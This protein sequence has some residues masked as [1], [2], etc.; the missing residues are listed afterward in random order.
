MA[1]AGKASIVFHATNGSGENVM[2][3]YSVFGERER[4][5]WAEEAITE[6]YISGFG[7][8]T[9]QAAE[10]LFAA[11]APG[12]ERNVLDLCC[13]Q[14]YLTSR[15]T[16]S[17]ATVDGLDFSSTMLQRA[18]GAAPAARLRQGDAQDLPYGEANF[19]AVVCNFGMMHIPDQPQ[20]LSEVRRVLRPGGVF[21]FTC[22]VGPEASPAFA[23]AFSAVR[24][25]ADLSAAPQQPDFF[26]FARRDTAGEMLQATGFR[27]AGHEILDFTWHLQAPEELF[28]I[29]S[30]GTVSFAM[31]LKSQ[32][33]E[34]IDRIRA[35]MTATVAADFAAD[36]GYAVPVPVAM[37]VAH[38]A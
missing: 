8:V 16:E 36:G 17:G 20:A 30:K 4:K 35:S 2:S 31:M 21:A 22:W 5:G 29:F 33:T 15:L 1:N 37:V 7:P 18:A 32:S 12:A 6:N 38:P 23:T 14:G 26:Q 27:P 11:V 3:D 25:H 34:I 28:D 13:G 9:D 24:A 19:D 10:H